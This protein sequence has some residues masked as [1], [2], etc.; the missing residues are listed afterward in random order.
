M[1]PKGCL[2]SWA[3]QKRNLKFVKTQEL[4]FFK[5]LIS[6]VVQWLSFDAAFSQLVQPGPKT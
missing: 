6:N 2:Q 3:S 4:P 1:S 5:Q